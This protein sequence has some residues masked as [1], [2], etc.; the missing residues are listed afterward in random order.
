[1]RLKKRSTGSVRN[2]PFWVGSAFFSSSSFLMR[3][4]RIV[5]ASKMR[6]SDEPSRISMGSIGLMVVVKKVLRVSI[7]SLYYTFL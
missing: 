3:F 4:P 7:V 2:R 1:M 5:L 6:T